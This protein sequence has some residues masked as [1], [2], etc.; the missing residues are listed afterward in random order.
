MYYEE[1]WSSSSLP[2]VPGWFL[3]LLPTVPR[4]FGVVK[5]VMGLH[6]MNLKAIEFIVE[7]NYGSFERGEAG[8]EASSHGLLHLYE[9]INDQF[10]KRD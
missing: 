3:S 2:N 7:L 9:S 8:V 5:L 4:Y 1:R 10:Y 6:Y